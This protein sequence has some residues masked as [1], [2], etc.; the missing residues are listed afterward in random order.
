VP[1]EYYLFWIWDN[2]LKILEYF[3]NF[4]S[5]PQHLRSD[6]MNV[7]MPAIVYL[8][9]VLVFL[10]HQSVHDNLASVIYYGNT[11]QHLVVKFSVNSQEP[12]DLSVFTVWV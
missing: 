2:L 6:A 5:M 4:G 7:N 11:T 8:L 10:M 1:N 12:S 3:T 9:E